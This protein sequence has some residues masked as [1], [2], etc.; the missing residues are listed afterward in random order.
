MDLNQTR[1]IAREIELAKLTVLIGK[2]VSCRPQKDVMVTVRTGMQPLVLATIT[3]DNVEVKRSP[4]RQKEL[5]APR[6][7][8]GFEIGPARLAVV[9]AK[10]ILSLD[11]QGGKPMIVRAFA[12]RPPNSPELPA[13]A[14]TAARND[15]PS[16]GIGPN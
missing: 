14:A 10:I 12:K 16:A 9:D 2:I 15:A 5:F 8:I 13:R 6:S 1:G 3:G 11:R 4:I 7:I